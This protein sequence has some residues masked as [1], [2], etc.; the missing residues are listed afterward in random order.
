M[1]IVGLTGGIGSGKSIVSQ[2]F[3]KLGVPVIDTDL[4]ARELVKADSPALDEITHHFGPAILFDNGELN[5][6]KLAEITFNNP[7][8]RKQLEAILHPRIKHE[9]VQ[10]VQQLDSQYAI[11]VIPLLIEAKQQDLVDRILVV[12]CPTETQIQRVTQRDHRSA[13]QIHAILDAQASREQRLQIAD[14]VI[15]NT[16]SIEELKNKICKLHQKFLDISNC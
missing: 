15:E 2:L 7:D 13:K 4:I 1:L 11:V 5:R 9:M 6:K 12:D 16:G 14:D 3:A 10:Q 8:Q